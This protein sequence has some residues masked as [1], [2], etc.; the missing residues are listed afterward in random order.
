VPNIN[1]FEFPT[2]GF[3]TVGVS[4]TTPIRMAAVAD[5]NSGTTTDG[6][7]V[8][9][10]APSAT[11]RACTTNAE[12]GS[13]AWVDAEVNQVLLPTKDPAK[14]KQKISRLTAQGNT[15][16]A[17]GMRWGT[18]LL[19]EAARPIYDALL[20]SEPGMAGRPVD[21]DS[22]YTRKIIILM[23]DGEHVTNNHILD[24]FKSGASPI[25]RT[26]NN[27][28]A[29]RYTPTG[30]GFTNGTRPGGTAANNCSGW[31]LTNYANREFF[32]PGLK[33]N[34]VPQKLATDIN[35]VGTGATTA[36]ACDPRSWIAQELDALGQPIL[37]LPIYNNAGAITGYDTAVP[38]D[39]SEVW[40]YVRV[41]WVAQQL[42][43]RSGVPNA[44]YNN[45]MGQFRGTYLTNVA[46]MNTLL[47]TN[48]TA[49]R[50][51]G[52]EIYGIAFAAP[53][54]GQT[55]IKNCSSEPKDDYYFQPTNGDDI[56]SVFQQI[57]T[58]IQDLRL[59]Q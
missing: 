31:V 18:A 59:T 58:R 5:A 28:F 12:S 8:S 51:A 47:Q 44:T 25:W 50:A 10:Q 3:N 23:T 19:D 6:T 38:L 48:C 17:V 52:I 39:W 24:A 20:A 9:P 37:R 42:Y 29:I 33:R 53:T 21:N 34:N 55:Q 46:N 22:I 14:V 1:C 13:T 30:T 35:E 16:I 7:V 27:R 11:S 4:L 2:S 26:A 40:R 56:N 41:S 49:A 43:A 45:A 36:G 54:N 32:V 57:A 15:Y